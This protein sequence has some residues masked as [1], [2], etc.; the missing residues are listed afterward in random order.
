MSKLLGAAVI[1]LFVIMLGMIG[2]VW[3]QSEAQYRDLV[4]RIGT[5]VPSSPVPQADEY[6]EAGTI[7]YGSGSAVVYLCKGEVKQAV[8]E[9]ADTRYCLGEYKLVLRV[10]G[11]SD[12]LLTA[13]EVYTD[14]NAPFLLD[15][16]SL[17]FARGPARLVISFAPQGC[18][19]D[20]NYC[21][22]G[23]PE[24]YVTGTYTLEPDNGALAGYKTLNN[25]P[26]FG[27]P[28]WSAQGWTVLSYPHTCGGAG[29]GVEPISMYSLAT[30]SSHDV[31]TET[32]AEEPWAT[33]ASGKRLPYW[34]DLHW[35]GP[36]EFTV[37]RVTP[38]GREQEISG[39]AY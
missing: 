38:D 13:G 18:L 8:M 10:V 9:D 16:D 20:E 36:G 27:K 31:T 22:V 26:Q 33:D 15:V 14:A 11:K 25:F 12:V 24:N 37:T 23:L 7:S 39:V 34:K 6:K 28:I 5:L 21:G 32:A 19:V 29:C 1:F 2:F 30:D 17:N 35:S 4:G 3:W